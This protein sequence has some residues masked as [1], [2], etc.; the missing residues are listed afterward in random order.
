MTD[1][2][3][4]VHVPQDCNC[5]CDKPYSLCEG[6]TCSQGTCTNFSRC[7]TSPDPCYNYTGV[8]TEQQGCEKVYACD[9]NNTCTIESCA[10]NGTCISTPKACDDADLCTEDLCEDGACLFPK[11]ICYKDECHTSACDATTGECVHT[12]VANS[13]CDDYDACTMD[14]C[15]PE[16]GCQ[17]VNI[18]ST[19]Q[20]EDGCTINSCSIQFG[21]VTT[22][23]V[24][25]DNPPC[26]WGVC[27]NGTCSLMRPEACGQEIVT[28]T[29]AT[30]ST[31]AIVGIAIA[32]AVCCGI[33][34]GA[35]YTAR[36]RYNAA[37]DLEKH[38]HANPL[39]EG[40]TIGGSSEIYAGGD[41]APDAPKP[42]GEPAATGGEIPDL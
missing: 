18:T 26:E 41:T 7:E 5:T 6:W 2:I 28:I 10:A 27:T 1:D 11:K 40:A 12:P 25:D 22:V 33:I 17:H 21:C 39:F 37:K 32:V 20:D 38:G 31:A 36:K 13:S 3:G 35:A 29:V 9:D 8:C 42:S 23:K 16:Q 30:I 15:D 14:Y 19:C 4:C 34:G 24:C